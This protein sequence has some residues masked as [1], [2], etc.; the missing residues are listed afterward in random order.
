VDSSHLGGLE[1]LRSSKCDAGACLE[2]A[3][4]GTVIMI[5]NSA[6]PGKPPVVVSRDVWRDFVRDIQAGVFDGR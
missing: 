3:V 5:R 4:L 6:E 2:V 1:W